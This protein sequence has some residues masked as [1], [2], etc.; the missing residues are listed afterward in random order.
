MNMGATM[1]TT[2]LDRVMLGTLVGLMVF[3]AGV[4]AYKI[5]QRQGRAVGYEVGR[6]D[7]CQWADQNWTDKQDDEVLARCMETESE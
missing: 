4:Q 1:K 2:K 6:A 7:G 5:G 3:I